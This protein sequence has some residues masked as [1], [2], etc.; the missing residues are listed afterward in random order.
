MWSKLV[1]IVAAMLFALGPVLAQSASSHLADK[2]AKTH[3]YVDR[4]LAS[5][6]KNGD[7][8][9][10]HDE[11]RRVKWLDQHFD[12]IDT[13][14]DGSLQGDEIHAYHATRHKQQIESPES[15]FKAADKNSDAGL[16]RAE[17]EA[18]NVTVVVHHFEEI[19]ISKDGKVTQD[20]LRAY[21]K[22]YQQTGST[23]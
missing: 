21:L 17:A 19:D 8:L 1:F 20:E 23:S 4:I 9:I 5:M 14:R 2:T 16:T 10:S 22:R 18:G 7:G 15:R 12:A 13:N 6:D 11:V 3:R